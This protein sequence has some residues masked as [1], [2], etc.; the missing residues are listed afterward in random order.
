MLG[1]ILS[2]LGKALVAIGRIGEI[3]EHPR[4]SG[5]A[6]QEGEERFAPEEPS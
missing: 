3:L 1:R 6:L 2:E 5:P 4:E